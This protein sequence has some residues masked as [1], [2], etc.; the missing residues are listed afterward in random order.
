MLFY[1]LLIMYALYQFG[2]NN[3]LLTKDFIVRSYEEL[4][5]ANTLTG[6]I[7]FRERF[8]W[9]GYVIM[10]SMIPI[11]VSY[12][13]I[14]IN[15]GTLLAG[16]DVRFTRIF[17]AGLFGEF[18]FLFATLFQ[19]AWILT[20]LRPEVIQDLEGFY[21]L[22]LLGLL[23]SESVPGWIHLPLQKLNLFELGYVVVVSEI[24]KVYTRTDFRKIFIIVAISYGFG[25]LLLIAVAMFLTLQ[26][27]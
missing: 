12:S 14:C 20:V 15:T 6:F 1:I 13:A 7:H 9:A 27:M 18:V 17:K 24:L 22:S 11:K 3:A 26:T 5:P 4:L 8:E 19:F 10:F 21:P 2:M 23:N 16:Y 25:L